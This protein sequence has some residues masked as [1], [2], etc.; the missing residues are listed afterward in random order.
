VL[1]W[2]SGFGAM[3]MRERPYGESQWALSMI[4]RGVGGVLLRFMGCMEWGYGKISGGVG[5]IFWS[6]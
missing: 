2:R 5:G 1:F 6:C 4:V 3:C